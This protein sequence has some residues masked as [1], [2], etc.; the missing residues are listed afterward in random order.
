MRYEDSF[1]WWIQD[2]GR[3]YILREY[4]EISGQDDG[5][6]HGYDKIIW[7]DRDDR[8]CDGYGFKKWETYHRIHDAEYVYAQNPSKTI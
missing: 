8:T 7:N 5:A 1:E 6:S 4:Y 3:V 2:A